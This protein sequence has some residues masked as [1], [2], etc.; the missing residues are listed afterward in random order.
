MFIWQKNGIVRVLKDGALLPTPFLDFSSKVNTYNDNGMLGLAFGP[1][2]SDTGSVYLTYVYEPNGNPNDT[3]T[4]MAR[5]VKVTADPANPDVALAGSEAT[6]LGDFPVDYGTHVL[7]TIRFARDGTMFFGNGDGASPSSVDANALGAQDLDSVRGKIFRVNRDGTAPSDNPFYDGTDSIRSRVWCYGVRNPYR[8]SLHPTTGE[9]YFADV[10]WDTWEEIDRGV[11][12]GNF[13]WPC[14]EGNGPQPGYQSRFGQCAAVSSVIAPI[15]TYPHSGGDLNSAG[16]CI[17][18]GDFYTG[19]RYPPSYEGN[20]FYADYSGN[21]IHRLV[22]DANGNLA[23]AAP[24][25]NGILAPTCVE[26]GPDGLLYYVSFSTGEIR[27]IRYNGPVAVASATPSYGYSPLQ[28]SFSSL[29]STN[30]FG[31]TLTYSWDFGDAATSSLANP[32]HTYSA[33]GV[34]TFTATLTVRDSNNLTSSATVKITV[35]SLPPTPTIFTPADGTGFLPGQTVSYQGS[36]ADP[37]EG[38]LPPSS[39][40]WTVLLHHNTHVHTFVGGTG[41]EGSFVAEKHDIIGTFSYEIVLTAT[42]SSGLAASTSVQLPILADTTSP[43]TPSGLTAATA[44][45]SQVDLS[46]GASADDA[47]VAG[48]LVERQG[49]GSADFVQ[50]GTATDTTYSDTSVTAN[51]S[52]SYRVRAIDASGNVSDYS[53]VASATTP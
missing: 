38:A 48:Y 10:G 20:Y 33:S 45:S 1:D 25:A 8:F 27:R 23:S 13:G 51:T 26:Q 44:S 32:T 9:P 41:S 14:Y 6:I 17:V 7:G 46:W 39:L 40:K 31:G 4:K 43:T 5:L 30:P 19:N 28:V 29:G 34:A 49:G 53:A 35:G 22:L 3:R 2:F 24:F 12:G 16:T 11:R 15:I 52:Y 18:G 36:A 42:D 50:I 21:W 47:A 37:D